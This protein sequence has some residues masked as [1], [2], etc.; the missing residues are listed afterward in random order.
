[1]AARLGLPQPITPDQ[2]EMFRGA[3]VLKKRMN[4]LRS[5]FNLEPL[6]FR[7]AVRDYL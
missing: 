4:P 2:L 3:S 7:V 1:V 6:P 5:V